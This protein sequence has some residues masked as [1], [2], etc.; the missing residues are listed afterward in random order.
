MAEVYETAPRRRR[1]GRGVLIILV[2]LLVIVLGVAFVVDRFGRS[3]AEGVIS[4]KVAGQIRAQKASSDTPDVT[5]EGFPFVT[6]VLDGH[7]QEIHI[8]VPHLTAPV[9]KTR[10]I[11]LALLDIHAQDVKASLDTLR[12]GSGDVVVGTVTGVS[13]ID[14]PQLV[15]LI[16][17][18]GVKLSAKDGKLI[19][20]ATV[21]ALGQQVDLTGAAKL[22]VVDGGIR[23]RFSDVRATNLPNVPLIQ[24]LIDAQAQRMSLDLAVPKLPLQ[25][26]VQSV[27]AGDDGLKVQFGAQNVN[28]NAGGL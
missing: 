28:L 9:D 12:N 25:L 5:I 15:E 19:G 11:N 1:R 2:I 22:T 14:Y 23:V 16:G 24:N 4:D 26:R 13:T 8:E 21:T 10:K 7:Y 6:Q 27:A 20:A 3:F 18:K 17:Q